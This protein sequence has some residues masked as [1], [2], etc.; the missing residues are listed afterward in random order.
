MLGFVLLPFGRVSLK[1]FWIDYLLSFSVL[2]LLAVLV[3]YFFATAWLASAASGPWV[4]TIINVFSGPALAAVMALAAWAFVMMVIKRLHDR[5][6]GGLLLVWKALLLAGLGWL[7]WRAESLMPGQ[8]GA[9]ISAI[10]GV[11][12]VL[13]VLRLLIIVMFL[14]GQVGENHYGRDPLALGR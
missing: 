14:R 2:A 6:F 3:D 7:A 9:A 10:A 8:A 12:F 13:L 11:V 1:G 5:G 4:D